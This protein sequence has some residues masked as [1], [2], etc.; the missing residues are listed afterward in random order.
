MHG[1]V[2]RCD[3]CGYQT[4]PEQCPNPYHNGGDVPGG[5]SV[6]LRV[7]DPGD[8]ASNP[9]HLCRACSDALA[10]WIARGDAR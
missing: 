6:I 2:Y 7:T 4:K 9:R 1:H 8:V 3:R 5:W 10:D